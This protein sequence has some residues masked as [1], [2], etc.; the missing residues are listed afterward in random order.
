[1]TDRS[2]TGPDAR[3]PKTYETVFVARQPIFDKDRRVWG[4]ELLY[5]SSMLART[6]DY[7]DESA[8][9]LRVAADACLVM[10]G[11]S[12]GRFK[13][14]VNFT[15]QTVLD[16]VPYALPGDMVVIEV[17]CRGDYSREFLDE[18]AELRGNG[19]A[20]AVDGCVEPGQAR[21]LL[22]LA[23]YI[24]ID[25]L[26][27][28]RY[29]LAVIVDDM[30]QFQAELVAQRIETYDKYQ[31]LQGLGFSLYQGHFF[32][33]P[34]IVPG[35]Q[36][37]SSQAARFKLFRLIESEDADFSEVSAVVQT[38]VSISYRLLALLNTPSFGFSQKISSIKQAVV[39]LGWRQIK[40]WLRLVLFTD[41]VPKDKTQELLFLSAQRGRFLETVSHTHPEHEEFADRVFLLGL[42]SL[43]D[44]ILDFPMEEVLAYLPL[45]RE[46]KYELMD[47]KSRWLAL[48]RHFESGNWQGL[49]RAIVRLGLDPLLVARC[50][51][52]SILWTNS[53]F[54]A[55]DS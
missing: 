23:D 19:Y 2:D 21:E 42:F 5:R 46:L 29:E 8:A 39:M 4:Y 54:E 7:A 45:E 35:R 12:M 15:E 24:K 6:A 44:A 10:G 55:G 47:E 3:E 38:D 41:M 17:Q 11:E 26:D 20:I 28:E 18:L 40:N 49:D 1:M 30:R 14:C 53:F 32:Q 43:L 52:E 51:H 25:V 9:T 31:G 33:K 13:L 37:S 16:R 48:S 27:R 22:G 36:L 34:R 50:Y